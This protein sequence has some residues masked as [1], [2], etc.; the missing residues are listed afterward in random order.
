MSNRSLLNLREP[1]CRRWYAMLAG[2]L[3]VTVVLLG[4]A[5]T[6]H[7]NLNIVASY[8]SSY[9][10]TEITAINSAIATD[11]NS[12]FTNNLTVN[13]YF[14]TGGGLGES[15]KLIYDIGYQNFRSGLQNNFAASGNA[16]QGTALAHLPNLGTNPVNGTTDLLAS[17]ADARILGQS[18]PTLLDQNGN[19][20]S[21]GSFIYDGIITLNTAL[22]FPDQPNNGSNYSL[23]AVAEHEIDEVLGLGSTVGGTG[24]FANPLA[25]DLYRFN[26]SGGTRSY[27]TAGDNAWFSIDGGTTAL[28]QFNQSGV[29]DYGDWHLGSTPVRVQDAFGTPGAM[30]TIGTDGG[31]EVTALNVIGYNNS[32]QHVVPEMSTIWLTDVGALAFSGYGFSRRRRR[33]AGKSAV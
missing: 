25:E 32:N 20:G 23:V 12:R 28:V 19:A 2:S 13:I 26:Q 21:G 27:T 3:A 31:A 24:F 4:S 1:A 17:S 22:T 9:T 16:N 29:G 30:P 8:S 6:A 7:A 5:P 11:Y 14:Q 10:A 18:T 15:N 33:G